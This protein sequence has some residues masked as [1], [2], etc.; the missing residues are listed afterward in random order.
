MSPFFYIGIILANLQACGEMPVLKDIF[1]INERGTD[2]SSLNCFNRKFGT[3]LGPIA[4]LFAVLLIIFCISFS[5]T[6][7]RKKEFRFLCFK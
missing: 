2:S 4:L 7:L 3:L 6:G 5:F 1:I